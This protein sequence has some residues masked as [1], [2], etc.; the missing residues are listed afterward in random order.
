MAAD[1]SGDLAVRVWVRGRAAI[2]LAYEGAALTTA[3]RY[4]DQAV[5]LS[6]RPSLGRVQA[7]MAQAHVAAGRGD[8]SGAVALDTDARRVFDYVAS[9]DGEVSDTAVPPWRMVTFR[10]MLYA[11]LGM[12]D[13]GAEAQ[14]TADRTRPVD[15][16]RFATHIE[17]HRGLTMVKAGDSAGGVA[18]AWRAMDAL[19]ADR[20][21]Q[22]LSL[23]L[24]EVE[25]AA[26]RR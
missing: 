2:V 22:S 21:S 23:M 15:L 19:P 1:R 5:A 17:L 9:A 6:D 20:R 4:A 12:P 10:S 24:R 16:P 18:Y 8:R 11:R 3:R 7:L 26:S 25:Q 13:P 14:E